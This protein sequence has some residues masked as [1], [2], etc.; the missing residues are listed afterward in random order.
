MARSIG[1]DVRHDPQPFGCAM[2]FAVDDGT[3]TCPNSMRRTDDQPEDVPAHRYPAILAR[4]AAV[5]VCELDPGVVAGVGHPGAPMAERR[6]QWIR[7][8]AAYPFNPRT[9]RMGWEGTVL[10]PF[11]ASMAK[12]QGHAD[13][14]IPAEDL[15]PEVLSIYTGGMPT[16][17]IAE[18][19]RQLFDVGYLVGHG[20]E[21]EIPAWRKFQGDPTA[22]DRKRKQRDRDRKV[23]THGRPT[24][25]VTV[26]SRSHD[27][28]TE[29]DGTERDGTPPIVP[30]EDSKEGKAKRMPIH[31]WPTVEEIRS[32]L[33]SER[34]A[35]RGRLAFDTLKVMAD[36]GCE[37]AAEVL[38]EQ[39]AE[40]AEV[41]DP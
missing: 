39:R 5:D 17:R 32:N 33:R 25:D 35:G 38:A 6:T 18:G 23:A 36:Q 1:D 15:T 11:V 3:T 26:T 40:A 12:L 31:H 13:G 7:W 19:L 4:F 16:D 24:P 37:T 14:M 21:V 2:L 29:R 8:E 10:F 9:L 20:A 27:D 28:G 41:S 22:S 34:A 30:R